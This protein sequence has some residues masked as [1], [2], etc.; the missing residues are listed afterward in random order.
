MRIVTFDTETTIFEKGNPFARRNK[1]CYIGTLVDDVYSDYDIEYSNSPYGH[2][3]QACKRDLESAEL[4]VG[5]NLKFDLHWIKRY[6]P[7][8]AIPRRVWDCQLAEFLLSHQQWTYPSLNESLVRRNLGTKLDVVN[9][10]Y[11]SHGLDTTVVPEDILRDY[12]KTDV[13]K[14]RKLYES[15]LEEFHLRD[16]KLLKLFQLQCLDLLVLQEME[17]NGMVFNTER[18]EQLALETAKQLADLDVRLSE[19]SGITDINWNSSDHISAVLYGG[20]IP[21]KCRVPTQR[22]LKDG[23]IKHGEK[24]GTRYI[25]CAQ[26]VKPRKGTETA[27]E[28]IYSVGEPILK[29]LPAKGS[30]R[31][32]IDTLLERARL[33]KLY[34]TYYTGIP[35]IIREKDWEPGIIHGQFNQCVAATGRLSSSNPNLQNFSGDIKD[36]FGTR[37]AEV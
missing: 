10:E 32:I 1:L 28:G 27:T 19:L 25:E 2:H 22:I 16:P 13:T 21:V 9:T 18:S 11:W 24:W 12:L 8:L 34:T 36:L 37:Y 5:F 35:D 30:A 14:T 4:V 29:S 3:L 15:Q 33:N 23:T 7:D 20:K 31:R 17:F 26:R 6:V